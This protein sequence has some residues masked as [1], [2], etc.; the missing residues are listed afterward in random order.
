[1]PDV[2]LVVESADARIR[3]GHEDKKGD[4]VMGALV[5]CALQYRGPGESRRNPRGHDAE[6]NWSSAQVQMRPAV[7]PERKSPWCGSRARCCRNSVLAGKYLD[8]Y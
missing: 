2:V 1:M 7:R 6:R 8:S 3:F 5:C 4:E